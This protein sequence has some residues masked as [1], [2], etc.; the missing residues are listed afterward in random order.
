MFNFKRE[1]LKH[2][3]LKNFNLLN[4]VKYKVSGKA[5]AKAVEFKKYL[6]DLTGNEETN[7]SINL[8]VDRAFSQG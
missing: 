2:R 1:Y 4:F 5:L 8:M 6:Y 7:L 3:S